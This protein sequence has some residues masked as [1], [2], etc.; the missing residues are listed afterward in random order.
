[1][2]TSFGPGESEPRGVPGIVSIPSQMGTSFGLRL[3]KRRGRIQKSQY[4]HRW[5]LASDKEVIGEAEEVLYVSIPSQ[6][7]TSFGQESIRTIQDVCLVSIPS[8]MGTSFGLT[9][10]IVSRGALSLNTL[11][12]GQ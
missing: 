9:Q 2:G 10:Q 12:D 6:M 3:K 4:P 1:M 8:Q 5:A 11:T 7:G